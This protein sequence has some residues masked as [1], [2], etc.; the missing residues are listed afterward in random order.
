M[1]GVIMNK[2]SGK[3]VLITGINGFIGSNI[4]SK[5]IDSGA[6]VT[7]IVRDINTNNNDA[8]ANSNILVGNIT[9]Y[10]FLCEAISANEIDTIFHLAAYSIVRVSARDPMS[11]YSINVMGTV[12]LLE[13]ARNVG[14]CNSIVVA[15]SDKAYGDHNEL[16][17]KEDYSLQPKNTYDTSKACMDMIARSYAK[18]YDMPISVTRCSNVYGPGDYNFSR[19]IPNTIRRVLNGERPV[20]YS[21]IEMMEREFIYIDDVV[22]AYMRTAYA[23]EKL[24][25]EAFNIGGTGPRK[26]RDIVNMICSSM[27]RLDLEPEIIPRESSFRE[28]NKQYIDASKFSSITGWQPIITLE[29]GIAATIDWYSKIHNGNII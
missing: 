24:S 23:N 4:A 6:H 25:G 28:I 18:N 17:Y 29:Q 1:S 3:N 5:L 2:W 14:R 21:D 12:C 11:T 26:I 15:S 10:G 13:A 20:L 16:P 8:L 9:D 19:I 7:G 22:N 27:G